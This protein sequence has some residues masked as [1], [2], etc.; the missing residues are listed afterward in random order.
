MTVESL[1]PHDEHHMMDVEEP[2]EVWLQM[3]R[4]RLE[5]TCTALFWSW[6][7]GSVSIS[8][9]RA[10]PRIQRDWLYFVCEGYGCNLMI[11]LIPFVHLPFYKTESGVEDLRI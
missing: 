10:S 5:L 7:T 4:P 8:R 11:R 6:P 2:H 9:A 3:L 1:P